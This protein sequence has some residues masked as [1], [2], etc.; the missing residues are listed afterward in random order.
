MTRVIQLPS[1]AAAAWLASV[2]A[3]MPRM[4]GRGFAKARRQQQGQELGLVADLGQRDD[5]GRDE[6]GLQHQAGGTV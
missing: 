1:A 2:A 3:R 4:I 5:A 6:E